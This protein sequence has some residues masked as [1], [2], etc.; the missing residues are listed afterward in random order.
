MPDPSLTPF[1][2]RLDYASKIAGVLT[3]ILIALVGGIYTYQ[4]DQNDAKTQD[5]QVARDL[6]QKQYSNL[7]AL[8]PMLLSKDP[9]TVSAALNVYTEETKNGQ[10]PLSLKGVI[11]KIGE[12]QPAL[13]AEA[14]AAS[15]AANLQSTGQCKAITSGLYV[16]V[17]NDP[18]QLK[19]GQALAALLKQAG[20]L[21]GLAG[22]QRVDAVPDQPQL[23]YYFAPTNDPDAQRI[24]AA[25][26]SFGFGSIQ[27]VD[28]SKAYLKSGCPPP[29]SF[30]L[31]MGAQS[32]LDSTGHPTQANPG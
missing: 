11:E 25:L 22:V 30:E 5:L 29:P 18:T 2:R 31:W 20:G 28:L 16:Q 14:Q 12:T 23:R 13:R 17:A 6:A 8:L 24:I 1:E 7:T 19:N 3:P 4:K 15:Q 27:R 32:P 21:P 10:A 9:A 26:Q